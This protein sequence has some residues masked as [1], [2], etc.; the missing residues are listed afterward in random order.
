MQLDPSPPG[1]ARRPPGTQGGARAQQETHFLR[2]GW[3]R[4]SGGAAEPPCP[5]AEAR[6]WFKCLIPTG[7]PVSSWDSVAGLPPPLPATSTHGPL[8]AV[9]P[10]LERWD[11]RAALGVP[12]APWAGLWAGPR[13][14]ASALHLEQPVPAPPGTPVHFHVPR[15]EVQSHLEGEWAWAEGSGD[16]PGRPPAAQGPLI[17]Y[18]FPLS[19][20]KTLSWAPG[21]LTP[22]QPSHRPLLG[23]LLWGPDGGAVCLGATEPKRKD[24]F[25]PTHPN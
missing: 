10:E 2:M 24:P 3:A 20:S 4:L 18:A 17:R 21:T 22:A 11:P 5:Q 19:C 25:W 8:I 16:R 7:R 6:E 9:S 15:G 12:Q 13:L 23:L 14:L 1:A